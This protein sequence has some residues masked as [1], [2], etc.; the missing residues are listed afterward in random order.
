MNS[1]YLC[2][3]EKIGEREG[4][5]RDIPHIQILECQECGLVFL[6]EHK[7]NE[8]E[9]YA[10]S[11][12]HAND[13]KIDIHALL[14]EYRVD[15]ARRFQFLEKKITNKT[16]LDFGCGAA[17]FLLMAKNTAASV[18]GVELERFLQS[19]YLKNALTVYDHIDNI[20]LNKKYDFITAFHVIEH[21]A[22]P[23]EMIA[24]LMNFLH[25]EGELILEVPSAT[26]ALLT[27]YKNE[28]FSHFTYWSCHYYLFNSD[29][30]FSLAKQLNLKVEYIKQ[31]QRYP[32]SNHLHWLAQGQPGGHKKW[33][34]LDSDALQIAYENQLAA[35]GM[36]D[37][38]MCSFKKND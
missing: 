24:T 12:M 22:D 32:L 1:C 17:G 31:I 18:A 35:L 13:K 5:V 27:L 14:N 8:D 9:F 10:E 30:L 37:T 6:S 21:L 11:G 3:S 38:L 7:S 29:N 25:Q 36:C 23:R 16:I 15:D 20:P 26:D 19:H 34:F 2:K 33:S 4:R 28:A